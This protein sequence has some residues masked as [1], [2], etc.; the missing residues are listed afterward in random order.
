VAFEALKP[1]V[2]V[3]LETGLEQGC[4]AQFLACRPFGYPLFA[5]EIKVF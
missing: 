2:L 4:K 5:I 3:G 1:H